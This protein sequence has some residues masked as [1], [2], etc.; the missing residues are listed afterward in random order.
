MSTYCSAFSCFTECTH[1]DLYGKIV[2]SLFEKDAAKKEQLR[3]ELADTK[4]PPYF[5]TLNSLLEQNKSGYFVGEGLTVA[6]LKLYFFVA[7]ITSDNFDYFPRNFLDQFELV[8][9]WFERV[10]EHPKFKEHAN[11]Y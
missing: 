7:M 3:K 6:D 1:P 5:K 10:R 2:A 4:L 9:A 11:K 8:K